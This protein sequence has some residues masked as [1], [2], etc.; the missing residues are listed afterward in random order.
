M[1]CRCSVVVPR[2]ESAIAKSMSREE[3]ERFCRE[4]AV[5]GRPGGV[6]MSKEESEVVPIASLGNVVRVDTLG[7]SLGGSVEPILSRIDRRVTLRRAG[8]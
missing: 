5:R 1:T 6:F 2:E 8:N 7:L 3:R 4:M